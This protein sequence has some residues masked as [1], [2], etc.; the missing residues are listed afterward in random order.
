MAA[1]RNEIDVEA[2]GGIDDLISHC[3]CAQR[4]IYGQTDFLQSI[5]PGRQIFLC[6]RLD[7]RPVH[8]IDRSIV[9]G[10]AL[11]FQDAEQGNAC[12]QGPSQGDDMGEYPL[13]KLLCARYAICHRKVADTTKELLMPSFGVLCSIL[14]TFAGFKAAITV[15]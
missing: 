7:T 3:A 9:V 14:D 15:N 1:E 4:C 5:D 13:R 2:V 6:L 11:S 12:I 8:R 10:I